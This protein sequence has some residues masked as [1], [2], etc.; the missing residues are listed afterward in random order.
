MNIAKTLFNPDVHTA[1]ETLQADRL[2]QHLS[3][4]RRAFHTCLEPLVPTQFA[5]DVQAA[6]LLAQRLAFV[7]PLERGWQPTDDMVLKAA[8]GVIAGYFAHCDAFT[9]EGFP[10]PGHAAIES[11]KRFD[12]RV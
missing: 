4:W 10:D 1:P 6:A 8:P 9:R 5:G 2:L 12:F 11:M 7:L 3:R